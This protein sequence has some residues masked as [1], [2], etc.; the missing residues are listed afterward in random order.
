MELDFVLTKLGKYSSKLRIYSI[1][2][3]LSKNIFIEC[4]QL[5]KYFYLFL[6]TLI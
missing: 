4:V 1:R 6:D 2:L 3:T 5:F